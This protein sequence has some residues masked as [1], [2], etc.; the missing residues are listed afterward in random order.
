MRVVYVSLNGPFTENWAYQENIL[1]KYHKKLGNDVTIIATNQKHIDSGEIVETPCEDYV[2]R[3]GV[4][5]VRVAK[6]KCIIKKFS[7]V[8][9]DHK[10]IELL[11]Q[12]HPDFIMV[13]G[14]I[15]NLSALQVRKYIKKINPNCIA[16]ADIHQDFYNTNSPDNILKRNLLKAVH[17]YLNR[18]MYPFYKKVFYVAP[19]CRK[20]AEEYYAV[21]K[22]KLDLLPLGC[23]PE[24]IQFSQKAVVFKEIR[25]VYKID[26]DDFLICHGGKMDE[27][28]NTI[29]LIE[30]VKKLHSWNKRVQLI[31]FGSFSESYA[32]V[33]K[34]EIDE[35]SDFIKY[36]G[37]LTAEEYYKVYMASDIAVFP[38][39]QSVLW[40]QAIACGT[41]TVASRKLG[42]EYLDLGGNIKFLENGTAKEIFETLKSLIAS[43]EYLEMQKVAREK[44]IDFFSYEN[45]AKRVLET[46]DGVN[47]IESNRETKK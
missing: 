32:Q 31:L 19:S 26:Q 40:Q 15:G 25:Y 46:A 13:H 12:I 44:G 36:T 45:I 43:N 11:K 4:R 9:P 30:A 34:P 20:F 8:F 2:N 41:A 24:Y 5:V 42:V 17:R 23:D 6:K 16:V 39:G 10:I 27:K 47:E 35:N 3:D 14:L 1:S 28:K 7:D 38:G 33:V 22:D 29:Y 18:K 21:P 37:M